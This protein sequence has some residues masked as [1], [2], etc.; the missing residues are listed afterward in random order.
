MFSCLPPSGMRSGSVVSGRVTSTPCCSIG[1]TTMKMISR[2][3]Q[4]STRGVTLISL[5][6]LK[7][8]EPTLWENPKAI[9]QSLR[10]ADSAYAGILLAHRG[11]GA[12]LLLDEEVEKLR[13]RVRHLD[14]EPLERIGEVVEHPRRRDGHEQ[15]E[16]RG[17][18]GLGD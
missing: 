10:A 11:L 18:E 15:A 16:R 17:D 6:T 3:R 14:L 2:T 7:S 1:V 5:R 8:P 4:T 13:R 9:G 12:A